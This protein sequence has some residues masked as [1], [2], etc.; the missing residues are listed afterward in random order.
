MIT[1]VTLNAAIDKTYYMARFPLGRVSRVKQMYAEPG[2]KGI[3][4]ARVIH[5][6]GLPVTATGFL[7]GYNGD[8]IRMALSRQGIAHDFV[9]VEEESRLCL[10]MIDEEVGVSTEVLEP[11]P[12]IPDRAMEQL[13]AAVGRLAAR[14]RIVCFSGSLPSGVPSGYY[15]ELIGIVKQA[16]ALAFLDTS[17]EALRSG[18]QAVPDFIKP[19]ED[20]IVQLLG[21]EMNGEAA[22]S[23]RTLQ[24]KLASLQARGMAGVTV[25]LGAEGSLSSFDGSLYRAAAPRIEAVNTVGC[26]DA[27]VAGMAVSTAQELPAEERIAFATAVGTANAL[28]A[29]AG[30]VKASDVERLLREVS[31]ERITG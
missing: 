6:L 24:E 4:V 15:A 11:G 31:V 13:S 1:T 5:Q 10:N 8:W 2:G 28:N 7:G 30:Y 25:S 19:N 18:V 21:E 16:G 26:G 20:E 12:S 14:S 27:F 3:N 9:Q 23:S 22:S 29:K 17:G